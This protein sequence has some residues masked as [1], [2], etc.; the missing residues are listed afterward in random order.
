MPQRHDGYA[1]E[2]QWS[3]EVEG[4]Y[5]ETY[6]SGIP[7]FQRGDVPKNRVLSC[8]DL[9]SKGALDQKFLVRLVAVH[10]KYSSK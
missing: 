1:Y 6:S 9:F 8:S 3:V 2:N 10:T 4:S 7:A 5:A